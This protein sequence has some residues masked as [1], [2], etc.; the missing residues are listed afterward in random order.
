MKNYQK[1]VVIANNEL[2]EGVY[3]ASGDCYS[4]TA[5]I[6]QKPE[7]GN[8]CYVIQIDGK[9]EADDGHHSSERTVRLV[10][11][12]PVEYVSSNAASVSG[13]GTS[14]LDLTFV[15]GVNGSYHN[16]GVD[17]IGLGQLKVKSGDGLAILD[18]YAVSCN[19]T[20]T[21]EGH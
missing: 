21:Y 16:N 9:H 4:F 5:D 1:P 8:P 10:F 19:H 11:N 12:Q 2:A 14:S 3:A 20:C 18:T 6:K 7:L 15:D 13:D 17:N